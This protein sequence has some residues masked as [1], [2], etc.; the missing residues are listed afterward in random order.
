MPVY[1][2]NWSPFWRSRKINNQR[3][4]Y[5]GSKGLS[6]VPFWHMPN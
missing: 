2:V 1:G 4:G 5:F 6:G 3:D